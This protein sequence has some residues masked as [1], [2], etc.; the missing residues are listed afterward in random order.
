M[1]REFPALDLVSQQE[2]L[3]QWFVS[4]QAVQSAHVD[5]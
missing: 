3:V 4:A 1:K 5:S 2:G